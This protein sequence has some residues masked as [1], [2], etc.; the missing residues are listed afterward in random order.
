MKTDQVAGPC[1]VR[2]KV[3]TVR[4]TPSLLGAQG[5]W[6]KLRVISFA[7]WERQKKWCQE[8]KRN[9]TAFENMH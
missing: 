2:E 8:F 6:K 5:P 7:K 1:A 9:L 3:Y 4:T